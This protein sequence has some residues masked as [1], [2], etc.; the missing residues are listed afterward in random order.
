[1]R[2]RNNVRYKLWDRT[3]KLRKTVKDKIR[4]L[5][6][7]STKKKVDKEKVPLITLTNENRSFLRSLGLKVLV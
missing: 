1:M 2:N 5:I 7:K 6:V 4:R 3:S